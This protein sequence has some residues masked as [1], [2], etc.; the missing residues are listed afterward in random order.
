MIASDLP[1]VS[2]CFFGIADPGD[3][4]ATLH[5]V[6]FDILVEASAQSGLAL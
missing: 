1:D 6:V 3:R 5:G 4:Q 2:K